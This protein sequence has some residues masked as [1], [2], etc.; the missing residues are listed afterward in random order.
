[1]NTGSL[2]R[3]TR[4]S[5]DQLTDLQDIRLNLFFFFFLGRPFQN[6]AS[7]PVLF[8][9]VVSR[10]D[11]TTMFLP[12][13]CILDNVVS[14]FARQFSFSSWEQITQNQQLGP[15]WKK[16]HGVS[17]WRL[18]QAQVV[19]CSRETPRELAGLKFL[20]GYIPDISRKAVLI[21]NQ[22]N[23]FWQL[24]F[25]KRTDWGFPQT[26]FDDVAEF[27]WIGHDVLSCRHW[28][29]VS[30][31]PAEQVNDFVSASVHIRD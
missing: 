25:S 12:G 4:V 13:F 2:Q 17:N 8:R 18:V 28:L 15:S 30:R 19:L 1:M 14:F 11:R 29:A 31:L 9:F 27:C 21:T 22:L 24:L 6:T 5:Q 3:R 26:L 7:G 10:S 20:G 23:H 16:K